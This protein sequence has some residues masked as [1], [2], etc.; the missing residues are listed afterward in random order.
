M[1]R[2][3]LPSVWD[4]QRSHRADEKLLSPGVSATREMFI[5]QIQENRP[6]G[7]A[8]GH[9]MITLTDFASLHIRMAMFS[10]YA[11]LSCAVS[12]STLSWM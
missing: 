3:Q 9:L 1:I 11:K 10:V 8:L 7:D 2:Q 12:I 5:R 6:I 4:Y